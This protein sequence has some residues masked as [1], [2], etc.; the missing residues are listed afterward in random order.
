MKP[1]YIKDAKDLRDAVLII[2]MC[3]LMVIAL[4][5]LIPIKTQINETY[6]GIVWEFGNS[7]YY[8]K[9]EVNICGEYTRYLLHLFHERDSFNGKIEIPAAAYTSDYTMLPLEFSRKKNEMSYISYLDGETGDWQFMSIIS[10]PMLSE[11]V[12]L[13]SRYSEEGQQ[14]AVSFPCKTREQAVICA[15]KLLHE[16]FNIY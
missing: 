5:G 2:C 6:A 4:I 1:R 15:K 7:G 10:Q 9:T 16:D 14:M 8:E 11:G 3:L 12:L 13:L